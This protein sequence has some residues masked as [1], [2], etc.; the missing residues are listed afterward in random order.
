MLQCG[1]RLNFDRFPMRFALVALLLLVAVPMMSCYESSRP[2][3]SASDDDDSAGDDDD[4]AGDDDDSAGDDDDTAGDDDD[5][6]TG[7]CEDSPVVGT[8]LGTF[9]GSVEYVLTGSD[10]VDGN[11]SFDIDC[12]DRLAINGTMAGTEG[13]GATFAATIDGDYSELTDSM[14]ATLAGTITLAGSVP[15]TLNFTGDFDGTLVQTSPYVI[16]GVW[17]ITAPM[18]VSDGTGSGT[19]EA[20]LQ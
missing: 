6:T 7:G 11:L 9:A 2:G 19:W 12:T 17:Q 3:G 4:T 10:D 15:Y 18:P 8:W 14:D 20:Q 13:G 16:N 5:T 1:P